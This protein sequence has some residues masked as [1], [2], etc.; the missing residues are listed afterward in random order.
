MASSYSEWQTALREGRYW[1]DEREITRLT[2]S[3]RLPSPVCSAKFREVN[4]T[5]PEP[6]AFVS[7]LLA[8][9][10]VIVGLAGDGMSTAPPNPTTRSNS[11]QEHSV[12]RCWKSCIREPAWSWEVNSPFQPGGSI[13]VLIA[14]Y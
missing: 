7:V 6:V 8:V 10:D 4:T 9:L 14:P 2:Y 12:A 3:Q 13:A 5:G 1:E 11:S